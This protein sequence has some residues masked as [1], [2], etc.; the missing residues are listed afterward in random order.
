[1]SA[2]VLVGGVLNVLVFGL[3]LWMAEKNDR[4]ATR[5]HRFALRI[6]ELSVDLARLSRRWGR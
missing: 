4:I 3:N 5:N 1:M 2:V 6:R